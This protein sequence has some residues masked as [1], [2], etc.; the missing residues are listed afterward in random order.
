MKWGSTAASGSGL[1]AF[2]PSMSLEAGSRGVHAHFFLNAPSGAGCLPTRKKLNSPAA[3][4][5]MHLLVPGAYRPSGRSSSRAP[6]SGLNAPSGAGCLP[7]S[8]QNR[9]GPGQPLVSMHLLVPG[10]Y[11]HSLSCW[12]IS[13]DAVSMHL[14]VPGAYRL[15]SLQTAS[16]HRLLDGNRHRRSMHPDSPVNTVSIRPHLC[17]I[18]PLNGNAPPIAQTPSSAPT[19]D[20]ATPKSPPLSELSQHLRV[21]SSLFAKPQQMCPL[22]TPTPHSRVRASRAGDSRG[23]RAT[24]VADAM[25]HRS[26]SQP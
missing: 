5:S 1:H 26:K 23:A 12:R 11:R 7:T 15:P 17:G 2:Q 16:Q 21:H 22:K 9:A 18:S 4:V 25:A 10:A 13:A 6:G 24:A 19:F 8:E 14:L 20:G 3:Q